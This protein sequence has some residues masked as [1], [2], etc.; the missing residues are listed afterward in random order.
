MSCTKYP[1]R[2]TQQDRRF[3]AP[4][5]LDRK[6]EAL[7]RAMTEEEKLSL[8]GGTREPRDKGKIGNA[9]YQWGVPRLGVP[10]VVMY[11][12]PAGITGIVETTGLPQPSLLGCT[13]DDELAYRFGEVAGSECAACSG[14]TLLAPQL[15]VIRSP[16]FFR[17]KD[18]KSE[19]SYQAARMGEA[20]TRGVQS[21]GVA[22]TVKHFAAANL[23]G[24]DLAHFPSQ[25]V[26][27]QTLHETYC[28]SFEAAIRAGAASLMNSYNHVNGAWCSA[29]PDLLVDILRDQWGFEG[30]VMSDWG[31]VHG[32]TLDKGLDMEMPF[33]AFNA[34]RR[35]RRRIEQG[36]LSPDA[37]DRAARHVLRGMAVAGLL[38]LVQ[39]EERGEVLEEPGREQP[40]Q[41]EWTYDRAVAE[42]LLERNAR[43]A[44]EIVRRGIVLLKNE[45]GALPLKPEASGG[46]VLI[47][48][49]AKYPVCGE[50]QER[51]FGRLER[52]LS[53]QE[54]LEE[55]TGASFPACVGID[56]AGET[57]PAAALY[58]DEACMEP[59]LRR[60]YG[61]LEEDRDMVLSDRGPGGG[62][63]AFEGEAVLDEDGELIDNGLVSYNADEQRL[64][65]DYPLGQFC[66]VDAAIDFTCGTKNYRN[67]PEGT[68]F[69]D[70]E[71]YTWKGFVKA[72]E[73]GEYTLMLECVGGQASFFIRTG[74]GWQLAGKSQM[75]EWAQWPWESIVCTPE[76]MGITSSKLTLEK[77]RAYPIVVHARQC[78][79]NKDLQLRLAWAMPSFAREN[80]E[81]ALAAA[82]KAD[83][84]VYFACDAA[85][86]AQAGVWHHAA[87]SGISLSGDQR[88]LLEDTIRVR[89]PGAKLIVVM[90][91]SNARA[92]G[93]W[94][95]SADAILATCLPGQEGSRALAEILTGRTN[96]SGKL[97][98]SWPRLE[99][100]T[101]L[102]DT[103][104]HEAE[105]LMGVPG[106]GN[107]VIRMSE[108]IFTGYRWYDKSGVEP[109]FPFGHGLSY[110]TFAYSD[111]HIEE[112]GEDADFGRTWRVRCRVTN[113]GDVA[114]DE[115]VQLYLGKAEVPPH[116]RM[117]EK[118]LVGYA[119]LNGIGP[120]ESREAVMTIDPKMLCCWDAEAPFATRTDGTKDKWVRAAGRREI[121]VGASSR[122][123]RLKG[124]ITA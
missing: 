63:A 118:Q 29:N 16:H 52:M 50:A 19:D 81:A 26:D 23:F 111:L 59:G 92:V 34:P 30:S 28:R 87:G 8:L 18:M 2:F 93:A 61:I 31:S 4:E 17:N 73:S 112:A 97:S 119:R 82:A 105:R 55:L 35:V 47:G 85:G 62:G 51:S 100:D 94:A 70:G 90:Q 25:Y 41:M 96:P 91:T 56:Y 13:W 45:R 12:G 7:I 20:E 69:T 9:G 113:T 64:P 11:D 83:T 72:P 58:Q 67:G 22:A 68:A 116:V 66:C 49:G 75:R 3:D 15:D 21:C 108:G 48:L 37:V 46:T 123:I 101:P 89:R 115:I 65:E 5:A 39:L 120:G 107:T 124:E 103:P 10:E 86:P 36:R 95:D 14:N 33:P 54:A 88:R 71:T 78:V 122:D 80:Y 79:K 98:Q 32:F 44:A 27:E 40:I 106:D 110:T 76:G 60:T 102:T 84:V 6:I 109:M 38:G 74:D 24:T 1:E 77:G 99:Q 121:L 57:I 53:G 43:I 117:A 104:E 42:G 114:G